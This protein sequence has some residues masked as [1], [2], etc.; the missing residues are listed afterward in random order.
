[1]ELAKLLIKLFYLVVIYLICFMILKS[2]TPL[3]STNLYVISLL[4]SILIMYFT[5]DLVYNFLVNSEIIFKSNSEGGGN[6]G[7]GNSG[8]KQSR[9]RVEVDESTNV[10]KSNQSSQDYNMSHSHQ[11]IQDQVFN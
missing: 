7:G 2:Q 3:T 1:M 4:V 11:F 10:N 5:F 9:N 8:R 6:D